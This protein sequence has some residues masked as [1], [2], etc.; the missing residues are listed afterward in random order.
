[1][2]FHFQVN[3]YTCNCDPGFTGD[4]CQTDIDE[5]EGINCLNGGTC[6]DSINS[7]KVQKYFK[8]RVPMS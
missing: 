5:C 8:R 1:M 3:G 2:K 6:T 7:Y 4:L